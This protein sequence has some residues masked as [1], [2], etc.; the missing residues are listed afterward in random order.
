[1]DILNEQYIDM[2]M[3]IW[4]CD[5]HLKATCTHLRAGNG[6]RKVLPKIKLEFNL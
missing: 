6:W 5:V 3:I 1:M 4:L 2:Q